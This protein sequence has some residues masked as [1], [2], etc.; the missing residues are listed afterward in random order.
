M[1]RHIMVPVDLAHEERLGHALSVAAD[2]ARHWSARVTYVGVGTNTPGVLAHTP[3]E[4]TARLAAFAQAQGVAHGI[5]AAA[6]ATIAHDPT[7]DLDDALLRAVDETG[8]DLVVMQSH[9]PGLMDY[10]WPSNG[11]K[12]AGHASA[13]VLV[14]RG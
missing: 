3:E 10:V 2:L 4:Y 5:E 12:I 9:I 8:A 6:H 11:G 14:V 7:T 13:S 1:F